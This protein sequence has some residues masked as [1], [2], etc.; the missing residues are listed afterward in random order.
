M[1]RPQLEYYI[2][3]VMPETRHGETEESANKS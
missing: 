2:Q 3:V 1:V